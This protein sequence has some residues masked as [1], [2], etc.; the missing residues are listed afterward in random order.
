MPQLAEA[1]QQRPPGSDVD[2]VMPAARV[3]DAVVV[4]SI[5]EGVVCPQPGGRHLADHP[6]DQCVVV[7]GSVGHARDR[8]VEIAVVNVSQRREH[9]AAVSVVYHE[10]HRLRDVVKLLAGLINEG[11]GDL[12]EL[13]VLLIGDEL[14][15]HLLVEAPVPG[16]FP[17]NNLSVKPPD[18]C[19]VSVHCL[20]DQVLDVLGAVAQ[21]NKALDL[22]VG[23]VCDR[24]GFPDPPDDVVHDVLLQLP[25][26]LFYACRQ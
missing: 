13:G 12:L 2:P 26:F 7:I 3:V 24:P 23:R 8:L 14:L 9:F 11:V 21:N 18:L 15:A 16:V 1:G 5:A 10:A 22:P 20:P 4:A 17:I 25:V 6:P 19:L